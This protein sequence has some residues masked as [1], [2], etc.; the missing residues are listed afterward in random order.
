MLVFGGCT[1]IILK[2]SQ[3]APVDWTSNLELPLKIP[4]D[5]WK[6][7]SQQ[8]GFGELQ[9]FKVQLGG[10]TTWLYM[11]ILY[12]G[13]LIRLMEPEIRLNSWYDKYPILYRVLIH[14]R[15]WSPDFWTI[16]SNYSRYRISMSIWNFQ[17][18]EGWH[19]IHLNP[20]QPKAL[21]IFGR[22]QLELKS[23]ME[24]FPK[25]MSYQTLSYL[26]TIKLPGNPK[27]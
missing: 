13:W 10:C 23:S 24:S 27:S 3:L 4:G 2:T 14:P 15:W 5:F 21:G 7:T 16:N 25:K 19:L 17:L 9:K 26:T 18:N 12:D 11:I 6:T 1:W 22:I 8:K 20:S